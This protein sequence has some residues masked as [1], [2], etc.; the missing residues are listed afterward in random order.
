VRLVVQRADREADLAA[1]AEAR[2][3]ASVR[4]YRTSAKLIFWPFWL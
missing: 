1:A 4:L 2:V 3:E